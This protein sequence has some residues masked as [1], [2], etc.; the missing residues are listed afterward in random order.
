MKTAKTMVYA[1]VAFDPRAALAREIKK[2][3][4]RRAYAAISEEFAALDT[5]LGGLAYNLRDEG[6]GL[7]RNDDPQ[8]SH[9]LAEPRTRDGGE[10]RGDAKLVGGVPPGV[11][12]LHL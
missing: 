1:P 4:F 11:R 3:G 7:H 2:P 5:V 6:D 10:P 9:G 8:L 12:A